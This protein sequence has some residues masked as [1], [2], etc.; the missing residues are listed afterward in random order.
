VAVVVATGTVHTRAMGERPARRRRV[1]VEDAR[2][3]GHHL[4]A[5]WHPGE[6]QFVVSTWHDDVCTGA[7]RLAA[8]DAAALATLFVDGLAE[9]AAPTRRGPAVPDTRRGPGGFVDRVRWL[10]GA[11][12][13]A[14]PTPG[15][16]VPTRSCGRCAT[17]PP[18]RRGARPPEA[19]ARGE[20]VFY[21][22]SMSERPSVARCGAAGA[23]SMS[24]RPPVARR[25]ERSTAQE[26]AWPERPAAEQQEQ[27]T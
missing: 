25:A 27:N 14:V 21:P 1:L 23:G 19:G 12:R 7:S 3:D 6:R 22:G 18:D 20:N 13:P 9:A 10:L 15:R 16:G 8:A 5:T 11:P 26:R 4:R 17:S 2:R 24:E